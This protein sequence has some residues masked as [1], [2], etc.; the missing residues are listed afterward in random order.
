VLVSFVPGRIRLRF[1]ELRKHLA[2]AEDL[3]ARVLGID[4]ITKVEMNSVTGGILIEYD[5][6][7]LSTERLIEIGK[8]ELATLD[9]KLD[10]PYE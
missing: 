3:K 2:L 9:I 5:A 4:G 10:I 6:K 1:K 7:V 8:R